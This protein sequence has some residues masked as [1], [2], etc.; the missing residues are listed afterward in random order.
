MKRNHIHRGLVTK[1][2][3]RAWILGL[4]HRQEDTPQILTRV[5]IINRNS[6]VLLKF[7]KKVL[8]SAVYFLWLVSCD[9][10]VNRE[11]YQYVKVKK[12]SVSV[13]NSIVRIVPV[14]TLMMNYRT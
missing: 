9:L 3:N 6:A 2:V 12:A 11:Q 1:E 8:M 13:K 7:N 5:Y 4:F 14:R 10:T